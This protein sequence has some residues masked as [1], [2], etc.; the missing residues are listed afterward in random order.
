SRILCRDQ[1]DLFLVGGADSKIN[2]L[3]MVRHS[4][5]MELSRRNETPERASRPFDRARDGIVLGEGA[6]VMVL[7]EQEH[8]RRR[9]AHVYAQIAGFGA[10][11]DPGTKGSGLAWAIRAA[12]K[13]A[14]IGAE[15]VD[16]VNA[17]GYSSVSLDASEARGLQDVFGG[18]RVPVPVFAAKS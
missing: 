8:A 9:G 11:F 4:L 5:F 17:H 16:H 1:A 15:D 13:E 12:L 2:P 7:E 18:C 14:E 10:A 6:G 3:S